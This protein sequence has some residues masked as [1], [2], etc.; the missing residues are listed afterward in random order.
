MKEHQSV[1]EQAAKQ[2]SIKI[3]GYEEGTI[4][5]HSDMVLNGQ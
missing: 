3:C 4:L 5:F 1:I 2:G